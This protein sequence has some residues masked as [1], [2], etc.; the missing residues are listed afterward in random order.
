MHVCVRPFRDDGS[1]PA[2]VEV[3]DGCLAVR[4]EVGPQ[5]AGL[6]QCSISYHHVGAA[7]KLNVTVKPQGPQLSQ[8]STFS[9]VSRISVETQT[10]NFPSASP[11]PL[12]SSPDGPS[13]DRRRRD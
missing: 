2:G 3:G 12:R 5:H 4:G 1:W 11:S 8:W 10:S 13:A 7:L 9:A 6:Y